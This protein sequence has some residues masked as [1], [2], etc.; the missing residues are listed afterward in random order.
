[1]ASEISLLATVPEQAVIS[2]H[3]DGVVFAH[4]EHQPR[5][6]KFD[7]LDKAKPHSLE[8]WLGLGRQLG[9]NPD[10]LE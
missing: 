2:F 5:Y 8:E 3:A 6:I 9:G 10:G 4:V 1:M 7:E